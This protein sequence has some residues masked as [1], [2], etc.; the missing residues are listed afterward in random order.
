MPKTRS[1]EL[2]VAYG[3]SPGRWGTWFVD[4][5]ADTPE[6]DLYAA[7]HSKFMREYQGD[8]PVAFTALYHVPEITDDDDD[9]EVSIDRMM[10]IAWDIKKSFSYVKAEGWWWHD[11]DEEEVMEAW[12]GPFARFEQAVHA[13]VEPYLE[14]GD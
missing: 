13:A 2:A 7:A 1:I 11:R 5:P 12:H 14:D 6:D 3:S 9:V 8:A 10:Q 4:I